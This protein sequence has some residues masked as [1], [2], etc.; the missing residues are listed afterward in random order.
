VNARL[1]SSVVVTTNHHDDRP[2]SI[3]VTHVDASGSVEIGAVTF[4][5]SELL[6]APE[7]A[8]RDRSVVDLR[9]AGE[10]SPLADG[11]VAGFVAI[12]PPGAVPAAR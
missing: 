3:V 9:L 12:P 11:S 6:A 7:L 8:L 10:P 5:L 1:D 2:V 4:R